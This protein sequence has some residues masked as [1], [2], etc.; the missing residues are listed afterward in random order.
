MALDVEKTTP[1]AVIE[2]NGVERASAAISH[3][4]RACPEPTS[5]GAPYDN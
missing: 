1:A 5:A 2:I 3:L 4:C